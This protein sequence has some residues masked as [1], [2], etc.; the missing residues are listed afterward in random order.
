MMLS[1]R[2]MLDCSFPCQ[3]QDTQSSAATSRTVCGFRRLAVKEIFVPRT[4]RLSRLIG[5][6]NLDGQT[7]HQE[8]RWVIEDAAAEQ[9]VVVEASMAD[10]EAY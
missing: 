6:S 1:Q 5:L 7:I 4:T 2:G 8:A 10:E 9:E 3:G